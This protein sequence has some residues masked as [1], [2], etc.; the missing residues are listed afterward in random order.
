MRDLLEKNPHAKALQLPKLP[1]SSGSAGAGGS[2]APQEG[3]AAA[4][5]EGGE[6]GGPAAA[7]AQRKRPAQKRK[8]AAEEAEKELVPDEQLPPRAADMPVSFGR[9]LKC[10]SRLA[11]AGCRCIL[12][13]LRVLCWV[14]VCLPVW[15]C[16]RPISQ[17]CLTP[18]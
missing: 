13:A 9:G 15:L 10:R 5:N 16:C 2:K 8:A 17:Q 4:G 6:E 14:F 1:P 3:S 7:G 11:V 12:G 18:C